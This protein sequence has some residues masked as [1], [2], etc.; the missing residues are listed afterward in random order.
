MAKKSSKKSKGSES[1]KS[2]K[3]RAKKGCPPNGDAKLSL[4]R[5]DNGGP[6]RSLDRGPMDGLPPIT[7]GGNGPIDRMGGN[8]PIDPMGPVGG[9]MGPVGGPMGPVGGP[10]GPVGGPMARRPMRM[11]P[12][13][14]IGG[15]GGS[16]GFNPF[17]PSPGIGAPRVA[18]APMGGPRRPVVG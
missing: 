13:A 2:S 5:E 14:P 15:P 11:G 6:P 9:P 16:L 18:R 8:G 10:M 3:S 1:K 4:S 7:A 17:R 12:G